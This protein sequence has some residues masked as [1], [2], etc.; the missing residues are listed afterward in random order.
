MKIKMFLILAILIV[1]LLFI[2]VYFYTKNETCESMKISDAIQ[3]GDL[4]SQYQQQDAQY[5]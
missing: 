4:C 5:D 1:S 3:I 2:I